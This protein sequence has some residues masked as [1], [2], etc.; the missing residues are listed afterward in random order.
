MYKKT[1][2]LT[3]PKVFTQ[4]YETASWYTDIE[5]P[6][7]EY[8]IVYTDANHQV[9]DPEVTRA[10]WAGVKLEGVIVASHFEN[11]VFSS[12]SFRDNADVGKPA[13]YHFGTYAYMFEIKE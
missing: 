5:V 13:T 7:G 4:T 8:P 12:V 9:V 3:E 11:R 1:F 10:Y 2:V 6:A